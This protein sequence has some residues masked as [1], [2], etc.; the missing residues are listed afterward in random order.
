M[1]LNMNQKLAIELIAEILNENASEV[2]PETA[3]IDLEEW[4][5]LAHLQIIG[6]FE[7]KFHVNI[8]IEEIKNITSVKNLLDYLN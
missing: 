8:P 6:E 2:G 1:E 5:S 3:F 7:D 4:D